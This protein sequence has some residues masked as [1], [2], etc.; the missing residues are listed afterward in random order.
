MT[1]FG[2]AASK[3]RQVPNF[4]KKSIIKW[5][6]NLARFKYRIKR[7]FLSYYCC[8]RLL[9]FVTALLPPYNFVNTYMQ[10]LAFCVKVYYNIILVDA[11]F[12]IFIFVFIIT[13]YRSNI[14][15]N[16]TALSTVPGPSS[17]RQI[18]LH[19]FMFGF[20][21]LLPFSGYC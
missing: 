12:M 21:K 15:L 2:K 1:F 17:Y 11:C 4:A 9:L 16:S 19:H 5:R 18:I 14:E 13:I 10:I 20:P 8:N 6:C 3:V 7:Y